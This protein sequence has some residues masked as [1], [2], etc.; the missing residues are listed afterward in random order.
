M[1]MYLSLEKKDFNEEALDE[2]PKELDGV[3][4]ML[5]NLKMTSNGNSTSISLGL[6]PGEGN[7]LHRILKTG[8]DLA[9]DLN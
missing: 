3:L 5:K 6:Q 7:S 9:P 4:G 8:I 1:G 2:I